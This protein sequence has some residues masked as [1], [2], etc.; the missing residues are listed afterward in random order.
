MHAATYDRV[1]HLFVS[2]LYDHR[3]HLLHFSTNV[4]GL[5]QQ[6][7]LS[8]YGAFS[9]HKAQSTNQIQSKSNRLPPFLFANV[10]DLKVKL[11]YLILIPP[12]L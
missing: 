9:M 5:S 3:I 7:S 6:T 12:A 4:Q 11:F 2:S 8:Y 10:L 1:V